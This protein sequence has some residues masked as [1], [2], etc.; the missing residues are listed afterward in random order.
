VNYGGRAE[1]VDATRAIAARSP[2]AGSTGQDRRANHR[3]Q[4]RRARLPDVDLFIRTSGEQ[5]TSNFLLWQS[6]Y[7]DSSSSIRR[8]P[9]STGDT[10]WQACLAYAS[11]DRRFGA[12][13]PVDAGEL[14]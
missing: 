11:R 5:R 12:A 14:S 2:R 13:G 6:A 3:G 7:A 1:I 10:C 9:T 4:P 8:G